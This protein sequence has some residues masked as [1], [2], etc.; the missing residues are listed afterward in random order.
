MKERPVVFGGRCSLVGVVT[1]PSATRSDAGLPACILLNAGVIH[2]VGPN[3]LHV[4]VARHLAQLG[5]LSFRFDFSGRGDSDTRTDATSFADA[6]LAETREAM[7]LLQKNHGC[8]RFVLMGI[9]SGAVASFQAAM[10]D[11]RVVG[12]VL[13]DSA[14]YPTRGYY[15]RHYLRR[16]AS[17]ESWSN[18]LLGH[19]RLGRLLR[20]SSPPKDTA[21]GGG[22][23]EIET[24]FGK[25][26]LP[27]KEETE[28]V[29]ERLLDRG[30]RLFVIYSG[31][32]TAYNYRDQFEDAFPALMKR[33]GI[34]VAYY[35]DCDHTFT[36]LASQSRL[37]DAIT[38]WLTHTIA[39]RVT[40]PPEPHS[41]MAG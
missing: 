10:S 25:V 2:H 28:R 23:A 7:D 8:G 24:L 39:G 13:I 38:H 29:I 37:V 17:R 32:W 31:S 6:N 19:N 36:R 9:C 15:L 3:R 27:P 18:V 33:G 20:L 16:L 14:A 12:A 4:R 35:P 1:E 34:Q 21:R 40:R 41:Q 22:G 11:P 26:V 30:V 5:V